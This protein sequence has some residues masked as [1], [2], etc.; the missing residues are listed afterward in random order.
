M[1]PRCA[2]LITVCGL[3][4]SPVRLAAGQ[5]VL[6]FY[7]D[8]EGWLEAVDNSYTTID[9]TGFHQFEL[10]TDQY[11]DLGVYFASIVQICNEV[12]AA[13]PNDFAGVGSGA[14]LPICVIFTEPQSWIGFDHPGAL[15]LTLSL[16]GEEFYFGD[17]DNSGFGNF[18]G[19]VSSQP[20]DE[21]MVY[22][23]TGAVFIDDLFFGGLS[24]SPDVNGDGTVDVLDLI[25]VIGAWGACPDFPQLCP[26]DIDGN[27]AVDTT[28]LV[29]VLVS[30]G[31]TNA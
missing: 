15:F 21:V 9:F 20:F 23:N 7:E 4:F 22:D 11:A 3:A 10:I 26:A 19:V 1:D 17:F 31:E 14:F 16:N 2:L 28:D 29:E 8:K 18:G 5:E 30:W 24:Y 27:G 25:A 13:F 12:C 6:D